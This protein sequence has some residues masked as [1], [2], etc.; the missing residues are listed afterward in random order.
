MGA[1]AVASGSLG[2]P[3][4][5]GGP[6]PLSP[7]QL[8]L[9]ALGPDVVVV[10]VR[11]MAEVRRDG[12]IGGAAWVPGGLVL[13]PDG[14]PAGASAGRTR[15]IVLYDGSGSRAAAIAETW[16]RLGLGPVAYL[17]GGFRAWQAAGLAVAGR[18]R[19]H[20]VADPT[21]P[22]TSTFTEVTR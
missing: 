7:H 14:G 12:W 16:L 13:L 22:P 15:T 3:V 19:W 1:V 17:D 18:A 8:E 11:V 20:D 9:V 2:G 6:R 5:G 21:R 4:S 10:D